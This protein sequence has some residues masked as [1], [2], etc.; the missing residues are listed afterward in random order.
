MDALASI[1]TCKAI[2]GV[3]VSQEELEAL[4]EAADANAGLVND[5]EDIKNEFEKMSIKKEVKPEP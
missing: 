2:E 5:A 1:A 4:K 3:E